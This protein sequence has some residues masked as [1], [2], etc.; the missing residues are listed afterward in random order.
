MN[1]LSFLNYLHCSGFFLYFPSVINVKS[2]SLSNGLP[3]DKIVRLIS[4][5]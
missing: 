4:P 5:I 2:L 3:L 1:Y